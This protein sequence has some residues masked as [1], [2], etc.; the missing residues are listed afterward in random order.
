MSRIT[1]E[2][3]SILIT[4]FGNLE[5][6]TEDDEEGFDVEPR[7]RFK[8]PPSETGFTPPIRKGFTTT[9]S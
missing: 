1:T 9:K 5:L 7:N 3:S 8:V 4:E 6:I 2:T